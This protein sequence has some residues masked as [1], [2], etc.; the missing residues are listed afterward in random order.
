MSSHSPRPTMN[1]SAR[2]LATV[3]AD[4]ANAQ[5]KAAF[6][7]ALGREITANAQTGSLKIVGGGGRV[8]ARERS[9]APMLKEMS[10]AVTLPAD[11]MSAILAKY[12]F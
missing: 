8:D 9:I 11:Q 3:L 5:L 2:A 6:E 1:I 10:D 7:K 12:S 4:P